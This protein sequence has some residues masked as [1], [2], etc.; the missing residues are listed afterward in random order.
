MVIVLHTINLEPIT[1]IDLSIEAYTTLTT[2]GKIRLDILGRDKLM[3]IYRKAVPF[4]GSEDAYYIF[5]TDD[6]VSALVIKPALLSGQ[7]SSFIEKGGEC[8]LT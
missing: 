2:K 4:E 1:V 6:E 3:N 8:E 7:Y 5:I